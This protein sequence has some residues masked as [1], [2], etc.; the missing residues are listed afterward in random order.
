MQFPP[1]QTFHQKLPKASDQLTFWESH[2]LNHFLAESVHHTEHEGLF[3]IKKK[4]RTFTWFRLVHTKQNF[5]KLTDST[6][7]LY[8]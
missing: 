5:L 7:S 8:H 4:E 2:Q 6:N 3:K 1:E